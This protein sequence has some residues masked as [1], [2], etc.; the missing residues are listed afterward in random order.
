[1]I[2]LWRFVAVRLV[3]IKNIDLKHSMYKYKHDRDYF[4]EIDTREKAY[5]LGFI[6]ADGSLYKRNKK[7]GW[8][9]YNFE[10][11]LKEKDKGHII[12]FAKAI[13]CD[14]PIKKRKS[15]L[16]NYGTFYS[17]RLMFYCDDFAKNLIKVGC[18]ENKSL[19]LEFPGEDIL[20]HNLYSDFIRGYFDGDGCIY[21]GYKPSNK[22]VSCS[23]SIVGTSDMLDNI[24]KILSKELNINI[25][26]MYCCGNNFQIW[27]YGFENCKK[28]YLYLYKKDC[29]YL[30]SKKSIFDKVFAHKYGDMFIA[31]DKNEE[32]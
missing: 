13:D 23:F 30:E 16:K 31:V 22:Q 7:E 21:Y 24:I 9:G 15:E 28:L 10:L 18:S 11:S 27:W 8:E 29:V 14:V 12:K 5:W 3:K 1:V 20:K 6:Y 17:S 4:K 32:S 19:L 25:P 2:P 26:K